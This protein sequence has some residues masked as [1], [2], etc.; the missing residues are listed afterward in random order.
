MSVKSTRRE[1][2]ALGS[3]AALGGSA[4]ALGGPPETASAPGGFRYCLNTATIRGQKLPIL[5]SAELVAKAGY[6]AIEPWIDELDR[7]VND[8]GTLEALGRDI[9]GL[10]LR[11][12]SAIGFFE[13]CVDD[14]TRRRKALD[15]AKHRFEMIKALGGTRLA[16]PPVG[17]TD[18]SDI[19][20]GRLAERYRALLEIGEP[21]GIVPELEIWGFSKTLGRL[22]E[23]AY[24]ATAADH[25]NACILA[26]VY[27]LHKGGSGFGGLRLFSPQAFQVFHVNDYPADPPRATIKD[28]DR[29]Y[30][31]DGV[32]PLNVVFPT[33]KANGFDGY[34]SIE[35]FNPRYYAQDPFIVVKTGLEKLRKAVESSLSSAKTAS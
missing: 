11:V 10:G 5:K 14:E 30:P 3:V 22:D 9:K 1:W 8:G 26:D 24:V 2:L 20:L 23:A 21:L 7:H 29:V 18:R 19:E 31:G 27:H 17:A 33:L 13:W 25:P 12:P 4:A 32:A 35:L 28:A 34:L 6:D 15:D 16:A